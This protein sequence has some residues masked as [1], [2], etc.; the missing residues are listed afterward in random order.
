MNTE[1]TNLRGRMPDN[2]PNPID[3]YVGIRIKTRR[4]VLNLSQEELGEK[5]GLTFQQIQKYERGINRVGASRLWDISRALGVSMDFFFD[6]M[7]KDI[8]NLSPA[9]IKN[10]THF[11]ALES[12]DDPLKAQ[13]TLELVRDYYKFKSRSPKAAEHLKELIHQLSFAPCVNKEE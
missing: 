4:R 9:V 1:K 11:T 10:G 8:Q 13:E 6:N 5:L 12:S 7:P 3:I 2:S